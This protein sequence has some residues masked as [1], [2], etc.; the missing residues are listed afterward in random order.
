MRE[1]GFS[2]T[3]N[4][5]SINMTLSTNIDGNLIPGTNMVTRNLE[6]LDANTFHNVG[7]EPQNSGFESDCPANWHIC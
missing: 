5:R 3:Y 2:S 7:S 4:R 1:L 6:Q